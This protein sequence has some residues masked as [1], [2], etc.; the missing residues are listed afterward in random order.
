MHVDNAMYRHNEKHLSFD[1]F[2]LP[3]GGHLRQYNRWVRLSEQI[4]WDLVEELCVSQLR[5]DFGDPAPSARR[6]FGSLLIKERWSA[7]TG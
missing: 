3:F 5:S 2:F 6:T 7:P 1:E 4:P